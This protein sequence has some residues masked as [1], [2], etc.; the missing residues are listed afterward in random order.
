MSDAPAGW[1][2][3]GFWKRY[4][5]YFIDVMLLYLVIETLAA[6]FFSSDSSAQL[7]QAMALSTALMNGDASPQDL[8]PL[9]DQ[10]TTMLWQSSVFSGVAYVVLGGLY[11]ALMESS[12]WQAT[13]GK[14]LIGIKVT[15]AQGRR[16]GLAR[17]LARFFAA[18]LSWLTMN[19]G[20][21]LAAWTPERRALHDYLAGTRVENAD[22]AQP[23]MPLWGWLIVAAHALIFLLSIIAIFAVVFLAMQKMTEGM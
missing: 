20:H 2:P 15:D 11:F 18:S 7:Q 13:L 10:T 14:R 6:V 4:V 8:Q 12:T 22:P 5:A 16:I 23:Q 9:L 17:A 1:S 21:A 3:A 19:I